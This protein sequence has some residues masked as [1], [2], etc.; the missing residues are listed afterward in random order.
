MQISVIY[1]Q[2]NSTISIYLFCIK[3]VDNSTQERNGANRALNQT[4]LPSV[5]GGPNSFITNS[6]LPQRKKRRSSTYS[7]RS[8][9]VTKDIVC[10][11][12]SEREIE[13]IPRGNNRGELAAKDLVGKVTFFTSWSDAM[14]REEISSVFRHAFKIETGVLPYIYLR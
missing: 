5:F 10:L 6:L 3:A 4:M 13:S 12:P 11:R 14:V 2:P 1:V 8:R 7:G 9:Q